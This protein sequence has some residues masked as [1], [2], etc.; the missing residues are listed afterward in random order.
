MVR[1]FDNPK[2]SQVNMQIKLLA[3]F[4]GRYLQGDL[5][6]DWQLLSHWKL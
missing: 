2:G 4:Y 1:T 6:V 3:P 5:K